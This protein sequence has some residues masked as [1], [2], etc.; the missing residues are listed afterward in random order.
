MIRV[1][2]VFTEAA[3]RPMQAIETIIALTLFTFG[4]YLTSPFYEIT[5]GTSIGIAFQDNPSVQV[6]VGLLL[7]MLPA[8]PII[9]AL[10]WKRFN[11]LKWRTRSTFCMFIACMFI[12]ILRLIIIGLTPLFWIFTFALGLV[13]AVCYLY[14]RVRHARV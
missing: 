14:M 3:T 1:I 12:T 8:L 6:A 5:S 9:L 2:T 4:A 13:S 7:Y 10:F 11:T